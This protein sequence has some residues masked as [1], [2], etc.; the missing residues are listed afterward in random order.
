MTFSNSAQELLPNDIKLIRKL[1]ATEAGFAY[2]HSLA[3]GT[4]QVLSHIELNKL[5]Q[6]EKLVCAA[7]KLF[8]YHQILRTCI[9]EL[10]DELWFNEFSEFERI[11]ISYTVASKADELDSIFNTEL[12]ESLNSSISLWRL[13]LVNVI[14]DQVSYIIFSRN[15]VVSDGFTTSLFFELLLKNL[16]GFIFEQD[17]F[18]SLPSFSTASLTPKGFIQSSKLAPPFTFNKFI[19]LEER[20]PL[21]LDLNISK[22]Q[23]SKLISF[24]KSNGLTITQLLSALFVKVFCLTMNKESCNLYTAV[25]LRSNMSDSMQALCMGC[26]IS[27]VHTVPNVNEN[28][29]VSLAKDCGLKLNDAINN[30]K[31]STHSHA[32]IRQSVLQLVQAKSANGIAITNVGNISSTRFPD[33]L[34]PTS[35]RTV[36]NRLCGNYAV[37]LHVLSLNGHLGAAFSWS[38]IAMNE[39]DAVKLH[40]NFLKLMEECD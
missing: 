37:V 19:K 30:W 38:N 22:Q 21:F 5:L 14:G 9:H 35:M 16:D 12:S 40:K 33:R 3:K 29:L 18:E 11:N 39:D 2:L 4:S 13:H 28:N 34:Q 26:H 27:V 23:S 15:H 25:S 7:R 32:F 31:P 36:V 1:T 20:K 24:A 10:G 17:K 6:Y 8:Y